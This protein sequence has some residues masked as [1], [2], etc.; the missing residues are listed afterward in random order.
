MFGDNGT[1]LLILLAL[2]YMAS[3]MLIFTGLRALRRSRG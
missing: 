3:G 2:T 1:N